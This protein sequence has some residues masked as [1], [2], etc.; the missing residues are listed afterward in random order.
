MAIT[1][2]VSRRRFL[3][4]GVGAASAAAFASR[5]A[6]AENGAE[7][8]A[9]SALPVPSGQARPFTNA[10]REA[11]IERAKKLMAG[12]K[13][14]A[15]VLANGTNSSVYFAGLRLNGGER[16]WALV[17]PVR[18]K[19]F[20]FAPRLKRAEPGSCS[21]PARWAKKPMC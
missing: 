12:A 10:E 8:P 11:R 14:D 13:I 4:A 1:A 6:L 7:P 18:A 2:G 3:G 19:P 21:L 16:L 15:I 9:I 5:I 17:I 20:L